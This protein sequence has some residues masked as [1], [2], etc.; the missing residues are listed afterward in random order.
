MPV[1]RPRVHPGCFQTIFLLEGSVSDDEMLLCAEFQQK[2]SVVIAISNAVFPKDS[3]PGL[4]ILTHSGIEITKDYHFII[5]RGVLQ[6][7]K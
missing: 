1:F 3:F 2:A 4:C 5:S 6:E 7:T